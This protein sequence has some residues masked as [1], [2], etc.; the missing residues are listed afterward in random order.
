MLRVAIIGGGAA[1]IGAAVALV[2]RGAEV[3]LFEAE[4]TLGGHC[5]G[6]TIP[7]D[8][9]RTFRV[10]AGVSDFNEASFSEVTALVRELGLEYF[11][12][13]QDASFMTEG[14]QTL[15]FTQG[16]QSHFSPRFPDQEG[17][18][19]E[20]KR[21]NRDCI[22][23]LEDASYADWSAERY[24]SV[25][26]YSDTFRK[27][28][29]APRAQGCF[30]MPNRSPYQ[31]MI[32]SIVAFWR[33]H[34]IVGPGPARRMVVKGGMHTYGQAVQTW[35]T[36]RN[37]KVHLSCHVVGIARR[38][39]RVRV[40][41]V[42]RERANLTE[43]FDQVVI[44]TNANQVIPLLEDPAPEEQRIFS[45]FE[46]QRAR[47]AVH[48]DDALMPADRSTWGAYNYIVDHEPESQ[49][50]DHFLSEPAGRA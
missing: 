14:R 35:L 8:E 18:V 3:E 2:R 39:G 40:R 46:W 19:A 24:L 7:F 1:G 6:M 29:F 25:R 22:E 5:Y 4:P 28:Y 34:G 31:Y 32:R 16:G 41:F 20:A 43:T 45:S 27:Y 50:D 33:M 23:V 47:V 11:P 15:W 30:P 21:F 13:C 10:D 48:Q 38:D 26:G 49:A 36:S 12:V 17:F 9:D 44:A 42:N 37:A